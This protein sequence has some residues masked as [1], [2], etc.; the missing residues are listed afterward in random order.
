M[1]RKALHRFLELYGVFILFALVLNLTL[2]I[3]LRVVADVPEPLDIL[4]II[5]FFSLFDLA[6]AG[7]LFRTGWRA[8]RMGILSMVGGQFLEFT[9]MRPEWVMRMCALEFSGETIAP[10]VISSV[11]YW[12]P[13]WAL[14]SYF[15]HRMVLKNH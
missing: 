3:L 4:G 6:G 9:F 11:L 5:M 10:F 7:I 8:K 1:K 2:E 12:F 14:P 13:A 15:A